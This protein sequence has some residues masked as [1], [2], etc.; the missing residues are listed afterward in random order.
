M[1]SCFCVETTSVSLVVS[2][3]QIEGISQNV[4]VHSNG[5]DEDWLL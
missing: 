1:M 5:K 3:E 2:T 4:I